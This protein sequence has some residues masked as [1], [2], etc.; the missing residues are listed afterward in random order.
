MGLGLVWHQVDGPAQLRFGLRKTLEAHQGRG[1]VDLCPEEIRDQRDGTLGTLQP[2]LE[3]ALIVQR[4]GEITVRHAIIGVEPD[5]PSVAGHRLSHPAHVP[6][7]VA[8]VQMRFRQVIQFREGA[9]NQLDRRRELSLL[10][11]D[12]PEKVQRLGMLRVSFQ[13]LAIERLR[14]SSS[15]AS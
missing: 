5:R 2:C 15:P 1:T 6:Q 9:A 4:A 14:W 7:G 12:E 8:E 13:R 10:I 11:G 3:Q